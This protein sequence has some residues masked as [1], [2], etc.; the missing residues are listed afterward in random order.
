MAAI[1]A[2][3]PLAGAGLAHA[4][5][6]SVTAVA[7][8]H[9][10]AERT[11]QDNCGDNSDD[12]PDEEPD[13]RRGRKRRMLGMKRSYFFRSV[14]EPTESGSVARAPG[15]MTGP[16]T[17][18]ATVSLSA[19]RARAL[20]FHYLPS[21]NADERP[22]TTNI[23]LLVVHSIS[24]PPGQFG[25]RADGSRAID[26]LFLNQLDAR[27]DDPARQYFGTDAVPRVSAHVCIYRDGSATQFVDFRRRAWHA[28]ESWHAGRTRCN[29]FSIGVELEGDDETQY[30]DAQ[31]RQLARLARA[32]I[33]AWPALTADRIVGH[34]DIAP[35]RK[36]DPGRYFDW[37]R[38]RFELEFPR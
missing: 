32:L 4:A 11:L 16:V 5:S 6:D 17:G 18:P 33:A 34:A 1:G 28:G 22:D 37:V 26:D 9:I 20:E 24:L 12:R 38:L 35:L 10:A 8:A 19:D 30:T 25:P 21:P 15:Q 3:A 13:A 14:E 23:S 2:L 36:T 27:T 31:Y 29:D 7:S